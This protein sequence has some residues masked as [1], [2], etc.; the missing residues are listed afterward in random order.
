MTLE[1]VVDVG[2]LL[3]AKEEEFRTG[4]DAECDNRRG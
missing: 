1:L 2:A 3:V 4:C